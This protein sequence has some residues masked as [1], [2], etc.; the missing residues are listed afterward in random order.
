MKTPHCAMTHKNLSLG[1]DTS[2]SVHGPQHF[3]TCHWAMTHENLSGDHNISKSNIGP[4]HMKT[5]LWTTTLQNLCVGHN[6]SKPSLGHDTS[7]KSP[8]LRP[9]HI[10]IWPWASTYQKPSLGQDIITKVQ[11]AFEGDQLSG[12]RCQQWN[13]KEFITIW[14]QGG[15]EMN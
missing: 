12:V 3:K 13:C 14:D 11:N 8:V 1:H 15:H 6:T 10:K 7:E 2:K 5:G 9:Q 4:W